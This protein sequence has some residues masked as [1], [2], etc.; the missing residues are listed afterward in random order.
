M[1][2]TIEFTKQ[3]LRILFVA[4]LNNHPDFERQ[5]KMIEKLDFDEK[6]QR[7]SIRQ[8]DTIIAKIGKQQKISEKLLYKLKELTDK[9]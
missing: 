1:K 7:D 3:E 8:K 5:K 2:K 4:V 9:L 6:R